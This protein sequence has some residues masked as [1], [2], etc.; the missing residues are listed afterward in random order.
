MYESATAPNRAASAAESCSA[1][2]E[3]AAPEIVLLRLREQIRDLFQ[4]ESRK[5]L[6]RQRE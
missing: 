4:T 3:I 6:A 5:E 2:F 1:S